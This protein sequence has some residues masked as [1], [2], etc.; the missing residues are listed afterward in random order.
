MEGVSFTARSRRDK[1]EQQ[2]QLA[3]QALAYTDTTLHHGFLPKLTKENKD[4]A[5]GFCFSKCV[6]ILQD[7]STKSGI[8]AQ[9]ITT[10]FA[11]MLA[12]PKN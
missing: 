11:K 3:S 8:P 5:M 4:F 9:Q 12:G 1:L 7:F 10:Q 6:D 2:A